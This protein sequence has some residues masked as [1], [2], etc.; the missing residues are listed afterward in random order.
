MKEYKGLLE[1]SAIDTWTNIPCPFTCT[2]DIVENIIPDEY[3]E[4]K[5]W[6]S[7]QAS[8]GAFFWANG[9]WFFEKAEDA[10]WFTMKWVI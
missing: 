5:Q 9:F 7:E 2:R 1:D 8:D 10:S 4:I 3:N 6:C